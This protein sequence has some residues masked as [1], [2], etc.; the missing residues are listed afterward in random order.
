MLALNLSA[1]W[2]GVVL[3]VLS[4]ALDPA[5]SYRAPRENSKLRPFGSMSN[6]FATCR[7]RRS[8]A[9]VVIEEDLR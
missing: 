7:G 3:D 9:C 5:E 1:G 8:L 2:Q 4:P 6:A